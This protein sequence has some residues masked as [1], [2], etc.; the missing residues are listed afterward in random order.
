MLV[1]RDENHPTTEIVLSKLAPLSE[2]NEV[3][4]PDSVSIEKDPRY[5]FDLPTLQ[6]AYL[7]SAFLALFHMLGYRAVLSPALD[8]IR[9]RILAN[10]ESV[11]V[12]VG[13]SPRPRAAERLV[14][15]AVVVEPERAQS[16]IAKFIGFDTVGFRDGT[17]EPVDVSV[18]LPLPTDLG[19]NKYRLAIGEIPHPEG[20]VAVELDATIRYASIPLLTYD[21][22]KELQ[23]TPSRT[24]CV[25][26]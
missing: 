15:L 26:R 22:G 21:H 6:T 2:T 20:V 8:S 3:T 19:L 18:V 7:K 14:Q 12:Y 9:S 4:L 10:N 13:F 11:P 1:A 23:L 24:Y 5:S 16:I 25:A 17:V